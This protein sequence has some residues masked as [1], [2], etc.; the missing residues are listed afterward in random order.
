MRRGGQQEEVAGLGREKLAQPVPLRVL[1]LA[2]EARGRHLVGLVADNKV[3][4]R[5]RSAQK[6]LDVLVAGELVQTG[7]CQGC[8][9]EPVPGA[10][11][12]EIVVRH[13]LE[14]ELEPARQ[15]V[16]P[17]LGKT[18][19]AD[20]QAALKVAARDQFLDQEPRHDG[21]ARPGVVSQ[22]GIAVVAA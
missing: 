19:G 14:P 1:D 17:L 4:P 2:S 21:L 3:P 6:V 7:D 20:D 5:F 22:A 10:G 18:A 9:H 8:L 11:G 16:L 13:D 12:F 15:L